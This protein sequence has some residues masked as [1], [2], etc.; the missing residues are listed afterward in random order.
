MYCDDWGCFFFTFV[1]A[2]GY[3]F[4]LSCKF[5]ENGCYKDLRRNGPVQ[6]TMESGNNIEVRCGTLVC[7]TAHFFTPADNK[8]E[9]NADWQITTVII[10]TKPTKTA[11][12]TTAK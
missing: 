2:G 6:G 4:E 7:K 1:H 5:T 11:T 12:M 8:I 3:Y 10:T 9:S